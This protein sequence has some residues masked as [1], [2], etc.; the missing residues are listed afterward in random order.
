MLFEL[1]SILLADLIK[2][3]DIDG[4][5]T[6]YDSRTNWI[7]IKRLVVTSVNDY[8]AFFTMEAKFGFSGVNLLEIKKEK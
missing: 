6:A 7:L 4:T 8:Y 3:D 2:D 5:V 1:H